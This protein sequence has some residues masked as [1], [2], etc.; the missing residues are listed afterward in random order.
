MTNDGLAL[1]KSLLTNIFHA[2]VDIS[3]K[4]RIFAKNTDM[5]PAMQMAG[6]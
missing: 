5:L 6:C 3:G 1:F 4:K 2:F